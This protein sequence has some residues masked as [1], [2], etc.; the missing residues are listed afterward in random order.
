MKK[1][2]SVMGIFVMMFISSSCFAQEGFTARVARNAEGWELQLICGI[3]PHTTE[4]ANKCFVYVEKLKSD[5][6]Y[7]TDKNLQMKA[8]QQHK[9]CK[10]FRRVTNICE[11]EIADRK[12]YHEKECKK[13]GFCK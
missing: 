13:S 6:N 8:Y 10:E 5:P 7:K 11:K 9:D 2:F 4:E 3:P 12:A 1:I